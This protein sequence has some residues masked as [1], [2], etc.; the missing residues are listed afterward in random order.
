MESARFC[1]SLTFFLKAGKEGSHIMA[2]PSRIKTHLEE[3]KIPYCPVIH[4]SSYTAQGAA[5]VMHIS[6]KEVAKTVVVQ[7]G[8]EYCLIV[9][10]A[11]YHVRPGKLAHFLGCPVRLAT[12]AEF[13]SLFPDCEL[14]AMP[15]L[16]E[17]YGL[18]VYV[19][20]SFAGEEE[21]VFNAGT[22]RDAIRMNYYDFVSLARPTMGSFAVKG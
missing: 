20:E 11:S 3:N 13:A 10:P 4:P 8:K 19:D 14:G 18:R 22:H 15:P 2:I 1:A 6:G 5:A 12:E 17:L 7:A 9:L 16:G 21:I